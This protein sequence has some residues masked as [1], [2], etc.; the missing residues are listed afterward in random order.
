MTP[1]PKFPFIITSYEGKQQSFHNEDVFDEL[2]KII[3]QNDEN[4]DR[5][6]KLLKKTGFIEA[7][8]DEFLEKEN[9]RHDME[10]FFKGLVPIIDNLNSLKHAIEESGE[11]EWKK[12]IAFLYEKF[13]T[14][15]S[16]YNF[17][18]SA[19]IGMTFDPAFHEAV[20]IVHNADL[21]EGSIAGIVENGWIYNDKILRF[22]KV[23]I[24]REEN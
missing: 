20:G 8:L 16:E 23:T 15:F 14:L 9:E 19:I 18:A 2:K 21:P 1:K 12:G 6:S 22:A 3:A 13:F 5:L 7:A 24:S 17:R 11:A 10:P 4:N